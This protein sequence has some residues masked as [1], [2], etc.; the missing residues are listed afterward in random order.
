MKTQDDNSKREGNEIS[1]VP[2][3]SFDPTNTIFTSQQI[4]QIIQDM[5]DDFL[6]ED[7]LSSVLYNFHGQSF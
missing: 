3:N 7:S 2:L 4:I 1:A 6:T 5:T